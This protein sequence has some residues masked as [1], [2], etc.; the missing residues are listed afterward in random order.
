MAYGGGQQQPKG[1][2]LDDYVGVHTR[3]EKFRAENPKARLVTQ[4]LEREPLTVR[5]EVYLEGNETGIPNA[6]GHADEG[7]GMGNRGRSALEMTETAAVGRAL[8]FL[9]YEVKEGIA[10]REEMQK[11]QR[12]APAEA[13]RQVK[14]APGAPPVRAVASPDDEHRQLDRDIREALGILGRKEASFNQWVQKE[15][16]TDSDWTEL[17]VETK[18]DLLAYLNSQVDKQVTAARG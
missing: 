2:G 7:G 9:G 17:S 13:P 1:R 18:R 5:A 14:T 10:S 16:S 12:P 3:V 11:A 6:V 8:A 15:H 4:I